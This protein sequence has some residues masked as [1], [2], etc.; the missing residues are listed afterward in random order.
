MPTTTETLFDGI[1]FPDDSTTISPLQTSF[2]TQ[3]T[4]VSVALNAI[5]RRT[6]IAVADEAE[7]D[8]VFPTPDYGDRILQLDEMIEYI[9]LSATHAESPGWKPAGSPWIEFY[10]LFNGLSLGTTGTALTGRYQYALGRCLVDIHAVCGVGSAWADPRVSLPVA[11]ATWFSNDAGSLPRIGSLNLQD[12]AG[13]TAITG[14]VEGAVRYVYSPTDPQGQLLFLSQY[15][16]SPAFV[17]LEGFSGAIPFTPAP[18]DKFHMHL[19]YP[20]Y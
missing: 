10:P 3:A 14:L 20:I 13:T 5:A 17:E 11:P 2:S 7:R 4:S 15:A 19:E 12:V 1:W 9:Y 18:G 8:I 6:P 16:S